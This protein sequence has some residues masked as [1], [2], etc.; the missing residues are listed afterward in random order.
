MFRHADRAH[1]RTAAAVRNAK[2]FV[3]IEMANIRA[4]I[5]RPAKTD[6]RVHVRAVHVN[7]AA[8]RVDDLA[9]FAD[10]RFE[11]AVRGRIGHHQ[12]GQIARM[13]RR[14][15]RADRRD[16]CRHPS[17]Q[18]DRDDFESGHDRAGRIGAVRRS[19][20]QT[21]VAMRF[22]A[23]SVIFADREQAGVFALRAGVRLQ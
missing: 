6:L 19:R 3:Q 15:W 22:A 14:P 8:V 1:A 10:G 18:R 9:N 2:S 5:A 20:N 23:R 4:D 17:R 11:N 12:R 13:L 21:N 16:R 7:L